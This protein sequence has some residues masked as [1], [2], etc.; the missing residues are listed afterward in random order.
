MLLTTQQSTFSPVTGGTTRESISYNPSIVLR[1]GHAL[2][3]RAPTLNIQ[4]NFTP[5]QW[6]KL[7]N[8]YTLVQN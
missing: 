1:N 6:K 5:D 4:N 8:I 7:E 2:N 3:D